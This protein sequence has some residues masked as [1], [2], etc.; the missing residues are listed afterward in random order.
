[1]A[2]TYTI[3]NIKKKKSRRMNKHHDRGLG[4]MRLLY[5]RDKSGRSTKNYVLV[6]RDCCD[7]F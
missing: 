2:V 6:F 7:F 4:V 3:H 1:M 5:T